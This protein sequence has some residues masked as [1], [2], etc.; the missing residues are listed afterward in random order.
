MLFRDPLLLAELLCARL[1]H[2][3][4]GPVGAAAAGAELF[5]DIGG[6]DGE[7]LALVATSAAGAAARL[8][9]F[10]A[11]LAPS[12]SPQP[13]ATLKD[14]IEG[15]LRTAV[16]AASSG[17]TL[18]WAVS[19]DDLSAEAARLLLN[20]VLVARDALPRGGLIA[21]SGGERGLTVTARGTSAALADEARLVL[22]D[23]EE[24]RGPRGAQAYVARLLAERTLG[25]LSVACTAEGVALTAGSG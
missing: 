19:A 18:A 13:T 25:R 10:R 23:G 16:S 1:C 24:P 7:T 6:G 15:Y 2:D 21:V 3:L 12:S 22:L 17:L 4:A 14:L 8:K 11:A 9:F 5:E 20:L